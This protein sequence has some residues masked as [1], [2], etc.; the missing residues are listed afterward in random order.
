MM[1]TIPRA[2]VAA[3]FDSRAFQ[4]RV[5]ESLFEPAYYQQWSADPGSL[6]SAAVSR[7][8]ASTGS[9]IVLAEGAAPGTPVLVLTVTELYADV[10]DA[11]APRAVL[12][13]QATL[14]D[15]RGDVLMVRDARS[16]EPTSSDPSSD[17][18]E[19]W[20]HGLGEITGSLVP[21]LVDAQMPTR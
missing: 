11:T 7:S 6:V 9:F 2:S 20:A 17:M 8:L 18:I 21:H 19:G 4:Y 13:M 10:R 3:P 16:D 5:G 15:E 1:L 12:A 14:V